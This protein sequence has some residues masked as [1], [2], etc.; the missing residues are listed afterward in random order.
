MSWEDQGRQEHG[1]FGHG[2]A[3]PKTGESEGAGGDRFARTSAALDARIRGLGNGAIAGL[4]AR[5]RYHYAAL[6]PEPVLAQLTE[7]MRAWVQGLGLDRAEFAARF[8][9]AGPNSP[10][11]EHL[12]EATRIVAGARTS[13]DLM[14]AIDQLAAGMQ[15]VGLDRWRRFLG[16]AQQRAAASDLAVPV[17]SGSASSNGKAVAPASGAALSSLETVFTIDVVYRRRLG[18]GVS[19]A[20]LAASKQMLVDG[21]SLNDLRAAID[22]AS[23][24]IARPATLVSYVPPG[25][26][27]PPVGALVDP[28]KEGY[29]AL[30]QVPE[31]ARGI[32]KYRVFSTTREPEPTR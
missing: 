27:T 32:L 10:T 25:S 9:G 12:R 15:A 5:L 2:T 21:A 28:Y 7:A 30:S 31:N 6:F 16:E 23:A 26:V 3:P 8:F 29:V 4:P 20:E 11:V 22:A 24:F 14:A 18:R 1:Y 13:A 19:A 17:S